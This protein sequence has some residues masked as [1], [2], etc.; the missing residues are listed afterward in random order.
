MAALESP[1]SLG[2]YWKVVLEEA[3]KP[4]ANIT[5][6]GAE[7]WALLHVVGKVHQ[8]CPGLQGPN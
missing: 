3:S 2:L 4:V 7:E 6:L 1:K 5:A 8:V